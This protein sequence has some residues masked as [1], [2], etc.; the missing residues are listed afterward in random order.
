MNVPNTKELATIQGGSRVVA[1][2]SYR[3]RTLTVHNDALVVVVRGTKQLMSPTQTLTIPT[4]Q[5]VM[6]AAG[7]TW[8]VVNDP[9]GHLRYEALLLTFEPEWVQA[10]SGLD[11]PQPRHTIG[12]ARVLHIDV[13]LLEAV[14]RTLGQPVSTR[15]LQHRIQEV[16]LWLAEQGWTYAPR[17]GRP[18][19]DRV[20]QLVAQRP[21]ADWSAPVLAAV[22]HISESTLRRRL[23]DAHLPLATLVR[24][25]RLEVALGLLQTTSLSA[26]DVAQRCGWASHSRF[27]AAFQTRWGVSPRL[28]RGPSTPAH[29]LADLAQTLTESG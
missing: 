13:P 23:E 29:T 6:M 16:L 17:H 14:Q 2:N 8:D 20:R 28:V 3:L 12:H 4:G 19:P 11:W 26:G 22:F 7:T 15:L 18:W 27:S 1:H 21:D 10:I 9:N 25:T 24:D 5:A